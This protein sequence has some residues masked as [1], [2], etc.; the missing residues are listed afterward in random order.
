[1]LKPSPY[2]LFFLQEITYTNELPSEMLAFLASIEVLGFFEVLFFFPFFPMCLSYGVFLQEPVFMELVKN[3]QTV[4]LSARSA[5]FRKGDLDRSL[6]IV[7]KG[8]VR[9]Y[10]DDVEHEVTDRCV[11]VSIHCSNKGQPDQ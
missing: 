3:I 1:V 5:V 7:T 10:A 8:L 2:F 6:Y 11:F 9:V 4:R